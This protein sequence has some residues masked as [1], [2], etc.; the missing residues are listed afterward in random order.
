MP[1]LCPRL[2]IPAEI[3]HC[4]VLVVAVEVGAHMLHI[5]AAVKAPH[6]E[7]DR[8]NNLVAYLKVSKCLWRL[9][10]DVSIAYGYPFGGGCPC[11]GPP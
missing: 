6:E 1:F 4:T 9:K 7:V 5:L 11:G 3:L 2:C 8:L 10:E